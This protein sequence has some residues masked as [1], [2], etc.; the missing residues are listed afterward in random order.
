MNALITGASA[1]IGKEMV[2]LLAQRGYHVVLV[3]RRKERL[4]AMLSD[5]PYGG[6]VIAQ[7]LA[8]PGAAKALWETCREKELSIDVLVNNAGFGKVGRHCELDL[9][10]LEQ[11]NNLNVTCLSS[12]C[13]L[14]GEEMKKRGRGCILNVGSTASYL[15]IPYFANYAAS[16]A[17]VSSFTRA[18][19]A[20]LM[21]RGVQV[22]LLNPGPTHSEFG[23]VAQGGEAFYR[24]KPMVMEAP[25][26]AEAG[27]V[28]MFADHAE[29][30][31]GP[32]N[33]ALPLIVRLLPKSFL[34]KGAGHVMGSRLDSPT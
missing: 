32:L 34:I 33:Q 20:E 30:V 7:D 24:G 14:F 28:G 16:K 4:E 17:F 26:V 15:P 31:P 10:H 23:D 27:I 19:R 5:L 21:P 29:I 2:S 25:E 6:T 1:G 9:D 18:L 11:M 3:A 13:R 22:S 8:L 12:L